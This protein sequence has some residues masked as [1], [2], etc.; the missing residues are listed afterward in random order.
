MNIKIKPDYSDA[1]AKFVA[2]CGEIKSAVN[3]NKAEFNYCNADTVLQKAEDLTELDALEI[4]VSACD[5]E[6]QPR[7]MEMIEKRRLELDPFTAAIGEP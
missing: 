4:D 1:I 5:E 2:N 7:L 3:T 6:I